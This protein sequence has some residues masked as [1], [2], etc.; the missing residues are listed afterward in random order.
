L[1]PRV[2]GRGHAIPADAEIVEGIRE[3]ARRH[4][5]WHEPLPPGLRLV[6]ALRLDSLRLLTLVVEIEN[7]FRIRLDEGVEAGIETVEDLVQVVRRKLA[8][9]AGDPR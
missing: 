5:G 9:T 2:G 6:E 3:V 1:R 7:H 8:A 4:L